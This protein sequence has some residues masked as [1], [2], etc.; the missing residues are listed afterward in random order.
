[1]ACEL[2]PVLLSCLVQDGREPN[3]DEIAS[4]DVIGAAYTWLCERRQDYSAYDDAWNVRWKWAEL[5]PNLQADLL[6]G[7]YRLQRGAPYLNR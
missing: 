3:L 4:D 5:K 2:D 7:T 6:A 1:V